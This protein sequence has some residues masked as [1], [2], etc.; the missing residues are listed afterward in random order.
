MQLPLAGAPFVNIQTNE[1]SLSMAENIVCGS[2]CPSEESE[3]LRTREGLETLLEAASS[4]SQGTE[5]QKVLLW[6]LFREQRGRKGWE[7]SRGRRKGKPR[8]EKSS[9]CLCEVGTVG[10]KR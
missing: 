3:E 1:C 7:G 9:V 4:D 2:E 8:L 6:V 10:T 5:A